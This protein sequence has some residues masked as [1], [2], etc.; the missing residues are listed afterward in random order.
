[1]SEEL[2]FQ[3]RYSIYQT[4]ITLPNTLNNCNNISPDFVTTFPTPGAVGTSPATT[5]PAGYTGIANCYTD[6][7]ASLPVRREL[8]QGA[9]LTSMVGYTVSYNTL[10]NNKN[11]TQ[12]IFASL[13]QDFA[14]L[15]GDVSF[16]R[17]TADFRTYYEVMTD[18]VASVRLQAGHIAGWG[19]RGLRMLDHF[20][21]G[22]TLVRGFA[23][24]GFGPRDITP[25]TTND[26]L[27]GSLYWGASIEF[28][29]PL[30]FLP[31][32]SGV[33]IATFIDA[34]SLWN[35]VGPTTNPAT[36]EITPATGAITLSSNK[37]FINSS[38]GV[39]LVWDSPF[40]PLRFDFAFPLT[41]QS[42][43]RTQW[44]RFGGGAR[45]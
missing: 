20:Q 35:Y 14:G 17:T 12:G 18:L 33:R 27:G 40:G 43:D 26:P 32:D 4:K 16:I 21:M 44:F 7:E 23:P 11:P 22:P 39:G 15:G 10:D 45:F 29:T 5:P 2:G 31:K 38:V 9:V 8:L 34:G 28:Q 41:K 24:S 13:T 30:Y 19:N 1:L 6:G 36:G 25:G 42:F 3:V 37:M